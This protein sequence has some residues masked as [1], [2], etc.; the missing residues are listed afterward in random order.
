MI[1][2]IS[3]TDEFLSIGV[4][5]NDVIGISKTGKVT[6]NGELHRW[7]TA[8]PHYSKH[9]K[10]FTEPKALPKFITKLLF[11]KSKFD[12][13]ITFPFSFKELCDF[14]AYCVRRSEHNRG[15]NSKTLD[16]GSPEFII[17]WINSRLIR[18]K[19]MDKDKTSL[20]NGVDDSASTLEELNYCFPHSAL[21]EGE[22]W[23][24][25]TFGENLPFGDNKK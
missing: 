16:A 25:L 12:Y 15:W 8:D 7:G 18:L 21:E 13:V 24:N 9:S 20:F 3:L 11:D 22:M 23:Y 1:Q 4:K 6:I 2:F 5:K 14:G 19:E 17:E 10:T